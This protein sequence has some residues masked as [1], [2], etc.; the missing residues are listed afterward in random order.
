MANLKMFYIYIYK[1]NCFT[2]YFAY[3]FT[4]SKDTS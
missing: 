4:S 1:I 3:Y 2:Y